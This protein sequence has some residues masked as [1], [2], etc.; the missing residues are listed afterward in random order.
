MKKHVHNQNKT[1]QKN[2]QTT[3]ECYSINLCSLLVYLLSF[4][5]IKHTSEKK[6]VC[7]F[8]I[9]QYLPVLEDLQS[10]DQPFQTQQVIAVGRYIDLI[11]DY[12]RCTRCLGVALLFTDYVLLRG[13]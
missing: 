12:I 9:S 3:G 4:K 6:Q 10:T 5:Y 13:L 2:T 11:Q 7:L 1:K 8:S